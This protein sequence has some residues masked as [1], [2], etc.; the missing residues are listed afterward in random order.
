MSLTHQRNA[1]PSAYPLSLPLPHSLHGEATL[2]KYFIW[3][4]EQWLYLHQQPSLYSKKWK[5]K[6]N[7]NNQPLSQSCFHY[8]LLLILMYIHNHGDICLYFIILGNILTKQRQFLRMFLLLMRNIQ[9][10]KVFLL[11]HT[12]LILAREPMISMSTVMEAQV[13]LVKSQFQYQPLDLQAQVQQK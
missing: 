3:C 1:K 11:I 13:T 4:W 7:W 8:I 10:P 5:Q 2:N 12:H 9:R 6:A